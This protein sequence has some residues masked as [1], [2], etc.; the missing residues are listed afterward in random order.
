MSK[1]HVYKKITLIPTRLF[2]TY[3]NTDNVA[4]GI[5]LMEDLI[6]ICKEMKGE[7]SLLTM[8]SAAAQAETASGRAGPKVARL[9]QR[10]LREF[11]IA[12]AS[13]RVYY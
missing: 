12:T 4:N 9:S 11:S 1:A 10:V 8:I 2:R 13:M 6:Q 5:A 3:L 7:L